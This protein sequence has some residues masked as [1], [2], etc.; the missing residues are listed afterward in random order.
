MK[1]KQFELRTPEPGDVFIFWVLVGLCLEAVN[2]RL[3]DW[4][5]TS[6]GQAEEGCMVWTGAGKDAKAVINRPWARRL[7]TDVPVV[8]QIYVREL[9]YELT[10]HAAPIRGIRTPTLANMCGCHQCMSP[11]HAKWISR[12]RVIKA[13]VER[14][15]YTQDPIRAMRIARARHEYN[16]REGVGLTPEQVQIIRE[17]PG[18]RPVDM[19]KRLHI[20]ARIIAECRRQRTYKLTQADL[21]AIEQGT[22]SAKTPAAPFAALLRFAMGKPAS[23]TRSAAT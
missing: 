18:V 3:E 4:E 10:G 19:A 17:N 23:I 7:S 5:S 21:Q 22:S 15:Q 2:K 20:P 14:T 11:D 16:R 1:S 9:L 13:A 12:S 8:R 6:N